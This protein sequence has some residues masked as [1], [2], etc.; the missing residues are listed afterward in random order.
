M[1][2]GDGDACR[3]K[4]SSTKKP[5]DGCYQGVP[6][7]RPWVAPSEK[8]P[9]KA[10]V[11]PLVALQRVKGEKL[12]AEAVAKQLE[13]VI[14]LEAEL[15]GCGLKRDAKRKV[16]GCSTHLLQRSLA[17]RRLQPLDAAETPPAATAGE[18]AAAAAAA[19]ASPS[20]KPAKKV[21]GCSDRL[22][23][24][25]RTRDDAA[26]S[27]AAA[28]A[29]SPP[30]KGGGGGGGGGTSGTVEGICN[31]L[32][33][34]PIERSQAVARHLTEKYALR[35][36]C[37]KLSQSDLQ[38]TA[39]RLCTEDLQGRAGRRQ[40]LID[41]Y[42]APP[43]PKVLSADEEV[44]FVERLYTQSLKHSVEA[45]RKLCAEHLNTRPT[46]TKLSKDEQTT[47]CDRLSASKG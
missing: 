32:Y 41:K 4:A 5:R 12:T 13:L 14:E 35:V 24:K 29:R 22:F 46:S 47:L 17:A 33:T 44:L 21:A 36:P 25:M 20:Q 34:Q 43:K 40:R 28:A 1:G 39:T 26:S 19:A 37:Q 11:D 8:A 10:A 6:I 30:K 16:K 45:Q 9:P 42:A 31:R 7:K 2:D 27:S 18:G 3:T 23:P 38:S 15:L